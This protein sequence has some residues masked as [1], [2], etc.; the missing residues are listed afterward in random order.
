MKL[1]LVDNTLFMLL[2][3]TGKLSKKEA[4]QNQNL[5][6]EKPNTSLDDIISCFHESSKP[7]LGV[8]KY[9]W[10]APDTDFAYKPDNYRSLLGDWKLALNNEIYRTLTNCISHCQTLQGKD[11]AT[12]KNHFSTLISTIAKYDYS[13]LDQ[14][15]FKLKLGY[16]RQRILYCG[17]PAIPE[18][19]KNVLK[20]VHEKLKDLLHSARYKK[21]AYL[22]AEVQQPLEKRQELAEKMQQIL[23][24]KGIAYHYVG[25]IAI[26]CDYA[27][28]ARIMQAIISEFKP[29]RVRPAHIY[30]IPE[31]ISGRQA[32][33]SPVIVKPGSSGLWN[34]SNIGADA[35]QKIANGSGVSIAII[36]TGIDYNHHEVADAYESGI[37]FVD[38][39]DAMDQ[40]GHGT[41]CAGIAAGRRVGV[42]PGA[43]LYAVRVLDDQGI[44]SETNIIRGMEWCIDQGIDVVNMSL[45]SNYP[46]SMEGELCGYAAQQGIFI[47]AAAGNQGYGPSYPAAF[48]GVISVAAVDRGNNHADFSNI[49]RT[50]DLSA[51]GVNIYS[52]YLDGSYAELS[53]TSMASPHVAGVAAL[54]KS[55]RNLDGGDIESLLKKTAQHLGEEDQFGAG[56]VRADDALHALRRKENGTRKEFAR[57]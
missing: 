50:N 9:C 55:Y 23:G 12:A 46:S 35:A 6:R 47:S 53:G 51:P 56:L 52:S 57:A 16:Y 43:S 13:F 29:L 39:I 34:L 41:H 37:D 40:N 7:V 5:L 18:I 22:M 32:R 21:E 44:G 49:W 30:M 15:E 4:K 31:L 42:A 28:S 1:A 45:G 54:V 19:V 24:I 36:D 38:G 14:W 48:D 8:G 3:R 26:T 20:P 11:Y 25:C 33:F 2:E 10:Y 27:E 17:K